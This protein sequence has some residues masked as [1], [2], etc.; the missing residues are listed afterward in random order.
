MRKEWLRASRVREIAGAF[1]DGGRVPLG[2][3]IV[4]MVH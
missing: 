2:E 4:D 1:V 3:N